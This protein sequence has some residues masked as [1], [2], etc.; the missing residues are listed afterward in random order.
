MTAASLSF[1]KAE[2]PRMF[3][4]LWLS[5]LIRDSRWWVSWTLSVLSLHGTLLPFFCALYHIHS[6]S[7]GCGVYINAGR[8][9]AVASTKAF[10][11]Q[12]L[13]YLLPPSPADSSLVLAT[14]LCLIALWFSKL[15]H[16]NDSKNRAGSFLISFVCFMLS[17]FFPYRR[18][19]PNHPFPILFP[20]PFLSL[21]GAQALRF[22][23][24]ERCASSLL[25][26]KKILLFPFILLLFTF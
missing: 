19:P 7:S 17:V 8:E 21:A 13:P 12:G 4:E 5:P 3:T 14:V 2:R 25:T 15:Y 23:C 22:S 16:P 6:S 20:I 24:S 9:N 18:F 1:L 10:T 26:F 11:A